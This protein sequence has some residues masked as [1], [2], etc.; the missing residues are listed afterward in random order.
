MRGASLTGAPRRAESATPPSRLAC[1][2]NAAEE[3]M[4]HSSCRPCACARRVCAPGRGGAP[5]KRTRPNT[6][7]R[8][9]AHRR[10]SPRP[11]HDRAVVARRLTLRACS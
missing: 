2:W 11:P 1:A 5:I 6:V 10:H 9:L 7:A 4:T 8:K 3:R